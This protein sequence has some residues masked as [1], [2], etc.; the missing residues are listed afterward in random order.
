MDEM[1]AVAAVILQPRGKLEDGN[2]VLGMMEQI[3]RRHLSSWQ[4]C[5]AVYHGLPISDFFYIRKGKLSC[6]STDLAGGGVVC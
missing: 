4:C 3:K 2:H 1:A 6:K 5:G